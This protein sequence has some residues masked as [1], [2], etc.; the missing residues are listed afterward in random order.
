MARYTAGPWEAREDRTVAA[1]GTPLLRCYAGRN[2]EANARLVAAAPDLVDA[3]VKAAN[4]L[5][6]F[7]SS[8]ADSLTLE[9]A[10]DLLARLDA[11]LSRIYGYPVPSLVFGSGT[12]AAPC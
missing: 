12:E 7:V 2:E 8:D 3:S 5:A 11:V 10:S 1:A 6:D 9:V 4:A